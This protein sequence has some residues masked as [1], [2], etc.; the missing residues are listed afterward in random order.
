[1]REIKRALILAGAVGTLFFNGGCGAP[2]TNTTV[3]NTNVNSNTN[4]LS[5]TNLNSTTTN[6]T[7]ITTREPESYQANV[8][9]S[10]QALGDAQ[11]ATMPTLGAVVARS[12]ADRV[13]E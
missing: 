12:G 11:T 13:M 2:G 3:S 8:R 5:N 9:L 1:M 7:A 6:T 4:L 10:L